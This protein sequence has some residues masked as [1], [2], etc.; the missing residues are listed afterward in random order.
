MKNTVNV[1]TTKV[2]AKPRKLNA[3]YTVE[4]QD[5]VEHYYDSGVEDKLS[6]ILGWNIQL[7]AL[8]DMSWHTFTC[9]KWDTSA[10]AEMTIWAK[11]HCNSDYKVRQNVWVF[12]DEKDYI[13]FKLRWS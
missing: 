4:I 2:T 11:E 5:D 6:E 1:T 7:A 9:E 12:E 13:M 3:K 8:K 10:W